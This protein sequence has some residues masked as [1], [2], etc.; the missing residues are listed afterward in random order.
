MP[1]IVVYWHGLPSWRLANVRFVALDFVLSVGTGVSLNATSRSHELAA[2][3]EYTRA[4]AHVLEPAAQP[5]D[6]IVVLDCD[7]SITPTVFTRSGGLVVYTPRP[8][9]GLSDASLSAVQPNSHF[10]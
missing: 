4:Y 8:V 2:E 3:S 1:P 7:R 6:E 10:V 9:V 5:L